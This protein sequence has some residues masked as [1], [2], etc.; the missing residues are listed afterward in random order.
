[1]SKKKKLSTTETD[2]CQVGSID[3]SSLE[4]RAMAYHREATAAD[5]R[6]LRSFSKEARFM[7]IY[8]VHHNETEK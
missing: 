2:M 3:Y 6:E 7:Y 8:G 4:E 1:M 5:H